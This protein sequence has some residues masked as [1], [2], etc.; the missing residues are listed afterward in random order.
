[1]ANEL[2]RVDNGYGFGSSNGNIVAGNVLTITANAINLGSNANVRITGGS[3][4][5]VLTTN[6]SGGLSWTTVSGGGSSTFISN[7]SSNIRTLTDSFQLIANGFTIMT[8]WGSN[9][10]VMNPQ[11]DFGAVFG[12]FKFT[13]NNGAQWD[14]SNANSVTLGTVGNLSISGGTNG[15]VL[16][17]NGSGGLSWTTVGG[18]GGTPGGSNTQ[19]QFN[20]GGSFGGSANLTYDKVTELLTS[21]ALSVGNLSASGVVNLSNS[22]NITIGNISNLHIPGGDNSTFLATDGNGNLFWNYIPTKDSIGDSFANGDVSVWTDAYFNAGGGIYNILASMNSTD[23]GGVSHVY[24]N[25]Y[26]IMSGPS[27][28]HVITLNANSHYLKGGVVAIGESNTETTSL[29]MYSNGNVNFANAA[30]ITLGNVANLRING[31]SNGQV[32]TTNGSGDLS[33]TTVGGGGSSDRI[34]NGTSNVSIVESNGNVAIYANGGLAARF[35]GDGGNSI[36]QTGFGGFKGIYLT[37][38]GNILDPGIGIDDSVPGGLGPNVS[39]RVFMP[40]TVYL[41]VSGPA[42]FTNSANLTLGDVA[43]IH[44]TGGNSGQV[45]S[46]DGS[47]GLSWANAGGTPAEIRSTLDGGNAR[48]ITGATF[49]DYGAGN[50]YTYS[51]TVI[52][53]DSTGNF[54]SI[55][56]GTGITQAANGGPFSSDVNV[57]AGNIY[58]AALT[59]E[60]T[61]NLS[62]LAEDTL[63]IS[64]TNNFVVYSNVSALNNRNWDFTNT[65]NVTLGNVSNLHITGGT[66]GQVLSTDG[67]GNLSWITAGGGGSS[68]SISNG[69]SNVSISTSGGNVIFGVGG[70]AGVTIVTAAGVVGRIVPRVTS[71]ASSSSVTVNSDTTDQYNITALAEAVTIDTPTGTPLDAQKLMFRI[72]DDGNAHAITWTTGSSGSFRAVGPTLPT[73]TAANKLLYVG[74]TWNAADARWDVIALSEEA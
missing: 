3:N 48:I 53:N 41:S 27:V 35:T 6:G 30:S 8:G 10:N 5:Q 17:T 29:V 65:A 59:S 62:I 15:Q 73:T 11:S 20:D 63:S 14:F 42:S 23:A 25:Y 55:P 26:T 44:I 39:Q 19:I 54:F 21:N 32:L 70:T 45:L 16:T 51:A 43:N 56:I 2:Y 31:G 28:N 37:T 50:V 34:S 18:G 1:M 22:A 69:T 72:R 13:M 7:G 66:S 74:C 60:G 61:G 67:T 24:A 58:I 33:W 38:N 64:A 47:G 9:S 57:I 49:G 71:V 46:T 36:I 52:L 12:G 68:D 40:D 4:G